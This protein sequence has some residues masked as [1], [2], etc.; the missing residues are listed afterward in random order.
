MDAETL[1]KALA[2]Y[3]IRTAV[4]SWPQKCSDIHKHQEYHMQLEAPVEG[5]VTI[6]TKCLAEEINK[7]EE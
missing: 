7:V 1:E 3:N 5:Q 2:N 6:C 4:F